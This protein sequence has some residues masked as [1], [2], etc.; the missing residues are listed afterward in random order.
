MNDRQMSPNHADTDP[1][2]KS[3]RDLLAHLHNKKLAFAKIWPK[4]FQPP[5]EYQ[6][7]H[8]SNKFAWEENRAR[9]HQQSI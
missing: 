3:A 4:Q 6:Q 1:R 2:G 9:K 7:Q 8:I 5:L